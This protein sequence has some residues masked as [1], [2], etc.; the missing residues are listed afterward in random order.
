VLSPRSRPVSEPV[1]EVQTNRSLRERVAVFARES[2]TLMKRQA[3][4]LNDADLSNWIERV[5]KSISEREI[6]IDVAVD[7][8]QRGAV[9]VALEISVSECAGSS[10]QNLVKTDAAADVNRR[11]KSDHVEMSG[12]SR[13]VE[14]ADRSNVCERRVHVRSRQTY[15]RRARDRFLQRRPILW[16]V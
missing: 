5:S 10:L 13:S 9:T 7:R 6:G 12:C 1:A 15:R 8:R 11:A 16:I 3:E 4:I 2:C 14:V